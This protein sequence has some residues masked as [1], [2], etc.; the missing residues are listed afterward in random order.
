M[1]KKPPRDQTRTWSDLATDRAAGAAIAVARAL[2]WRVRVP[3]MGRILSGVAGSLR[4]RDRA[5][6]NLEFIWPDMDPD[7]RQRIA[8]AVLDNMGRTLIENVDTS[9]LLARAGDWPPHGPGV[10]ALERARAEGRPAILVSGHFGNWEAARAA[11]T[12]AGFEVGGLYRPLNNGYL[13]DR[14]AGAL[15]ALGGPV[16]P[17]GREGLKGFVRFLKGGGFGIIFPDQ[18]VA[19]GEMLDFLGQPAPTTLSPAELAARYGAL[20]VPFYGIRAENGLDFEVLVE[21]PIEPGDP[22]ET[23][24]A[25]NDSLAAQVR[26]RPGQWLW[27]HRRW[28]HARLKRYGMLPVEPET[29]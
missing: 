5:M 14:H 27:V 20:I 28:K 17:R 26:K 29:D 6:E 1:A 4:F 21:D 25:I 22:A 16:F 24:Q 13:D 12:R 7:E 11:L 10:A 3:L 2:P 23:M 15:S 19:D 9:G 8:A 18:F